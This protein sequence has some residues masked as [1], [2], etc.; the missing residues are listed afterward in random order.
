VEPYRRP[1]EN[2]DKSHQLAYHYLQHQLHI[3]KILVN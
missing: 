2:Q 1:F 3:L